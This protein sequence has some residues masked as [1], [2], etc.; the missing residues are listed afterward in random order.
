MASGF[1]AVYQALLMFLLGIPIYAFLKARRE[2][3][4]EAFEPDETIGVEGGAFAPVVASAEGVTTSS[5]GP[6]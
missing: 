5:N 1:Q 6:S 4:G 3:R 2:R